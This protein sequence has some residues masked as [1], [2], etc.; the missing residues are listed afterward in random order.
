MS[1]L[2]MI[3]YQETVSGFPVHFDTVDRHPGDLAICYADFNLAREK[4]GWTAQRNIYHMC[5]DAWRW[6]SAFGFVAE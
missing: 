2:E 1:V 3:H 5:R 4:L 6:Q